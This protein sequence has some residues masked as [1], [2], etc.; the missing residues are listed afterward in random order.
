MARLAHLGRDRHSA[1][2]TRRHPSRMRSSCRFSSLKERSPDD[3][4]HD[5][6]RDADRARQ[7]PGERI[8]QRRGAAA[9][10]RRDAE[11]R[12]PALGQCG[13]DRRAEHHGSRPRGGRPGGRRDRRQPAA[14]QD[15]PRHRRRHARAP[16]L[17]PGDR[18]RPAGRRAHRARHRGRLAE[19][20]DAALPDGEAR[21]R[22][23]RAG[24]LRV[25]AALS[26]GARR[27]DL[28]G[29]AA[30]QAVG[31]QPAGRAHSAA[32]HRHR[33]LPDRRGVRRAQ[34]DLRQGRGR[35]VHRRSEEGQGRD[36][37]PAHQRAGPARARPRRSGGRTRGAR[38][39]AARAPH[40]ARSS[41][42]TG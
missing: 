35:A 6:K 2:S 10:D 4:E 9:G 30:L 15:D 26:D 19:R 11:R 22:V 37:H 40:R 25:A 24:R 41:S 5:R 33:L 28:P 42:S 20:A 16:R 29:H 38:P 12:D 36:A 7:A 23:P 1:R 21:H 31:R 14:P 34:D 8:A 32:A 17:Q 13:E 18:P 39:D 27:R 3:A